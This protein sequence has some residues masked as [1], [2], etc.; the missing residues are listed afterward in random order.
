MNRALYIL[1][2]GNSV[3]WGQ[4]DDT[5][6]TGPMSPYYGIWIED[7]WHS[8]ISH[9]WFTTQAPANS[10]HM[11]GDNFRTRVQ[12][13]H[14]GMDTLQPATDTERWGGDLPVGASYFSTTTKQ[15]KWWDGSDWTTADGLAEDALRNTLD[16][17]GDSTVRKTLRYTTDGTV[18]WVHGLRT[19]AE[20]NGF[21]LSRYD[22]AGYVEDSLAVSGSTGTV[23]T[24]QQLIQSNSASR[25]PLEVRAAASPTNSF[26]IVADSAGTPKFSVLWDGTLR[27]NWGSSGFAMTQVGCLQVVR[28][29]ASG[30][31]TMIGAYTS[32]ANASSS[33]PVF[34]VQADGSVW[35]D[36]VLGSGDGGKYLT[37]KAYVDAI[38]TSLK[39]EVAASTDFADFQS[40]IA[41]W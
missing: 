21:L 18:R 40:R 24:K 25:T 2:T 39:A 30:S 19:D 15:P 36:Y 9:S 20:G 11:V 10:L 3:T 5:G 35:S 26:F 16:I 22:G 31:Q 14:L 28:Q 12:S 37:P 33:S 29:G 38:K 23:T 34:E 17:D 27:S 8:D 4:A 41:S 32:T 13:A 6:G 1:F 7:T